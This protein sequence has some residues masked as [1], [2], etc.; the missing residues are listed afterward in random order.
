MPWAPS[1]RHSALRTVLTWP[2]MLE[3]PEPMHERAC[4]HGR[5]MKLRC[6]HFTP[7]LAS[8]TTMRRPRVCVL[9]PHMPSAAQ[10]EAHLPHPVIG[11]RMQST[12]HG[13]KL[14]AR[15]SVRV[16]HAFPPR[17]AGCTIW[18][19]LACAPDPSPMPHDL[20]QSP[21]DDHLPA[22]QSTAGHTF[23][24]HC[25]FC[26]SEPHGEPRNMGL[27]STFRVRVCRPPPH[28]T[29]HLVHEAHAL[30]TQFLALHS[31]MLHSCFSCAGSHAVP[32]CCGLTSTL[33][34]RACAP[35]CLPHEHLRSHADHADHCDSLQSTFAHGTVLQGAVRCSAGQ[36]MPPSMACFFTTRVWLYVPPPHLREQPVKRVHGPTSQ[37][38]GH[39]PS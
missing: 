2:H 11:E 8:A 24:P 6:G 31:C 21:H 34:C 26:Q 12:G 18:R 36:A 14:H 16:G 38:N 39:G 4:W 35:T 33:R 37:L 13:S 32:P 22:L 20:E 28:V 25:C 5:E 23:V 1:T 7:P 15:L 10:S 27:C 29:L 3:A 17:R 19:V 30:T 9:L